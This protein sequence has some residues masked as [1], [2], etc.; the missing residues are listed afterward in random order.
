MIITCE[1]LNTFENINLSKFYLRLAFDGVSTYECYLKYNNR[2][3]IVKDRRYFIPEQRLSLE[4]MIDVVRPICPLS[5][6]SL[7]Y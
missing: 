4:F 5:S 7:E 6:G 2:K 1:I 3:Y